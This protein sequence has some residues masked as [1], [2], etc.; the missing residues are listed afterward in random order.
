MSDYFEINFLP[1]AL[2]FGVL[3]YAFEPFDLPEHLE[4]GSDDSLIPIKA[5]GRDIRVP[6]ALVDVTSD[7]SK[8]ATNFELALKKAVPEL[9]S[10]GGSMWTVRIVRG[11][12]PELEDALEGMDEYVACVF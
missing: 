5:N 7:I 11:K 8:F 2:L 3:V 4:E 12:R 9:P 1:C 6:S 10:T